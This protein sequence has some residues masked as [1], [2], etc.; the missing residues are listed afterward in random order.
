[1]LKELVKMLA[2][3]ENRGRVNFNTLQYK[4]YILCSLLI[5]DK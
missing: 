5:Q 4:R 3:S 2:G 1:M